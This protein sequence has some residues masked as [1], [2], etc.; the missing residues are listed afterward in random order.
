MIRAIFH[1][2]L[3]FLLP[4][5]VA[6]KFYAE[7]WQRAWLV[8]MAT[9]L[10]DLDH[11]LADPLYAPDRCSIGFHPLHTAWP[12]LIYLLLC[13]W[14]KTRWVGIGLVIHMVLDGIDCWMMFS[15]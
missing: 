15:G 7:R 14:S 8:M 9:M 11:L 10:V 4:A 6:K 5:A 13:F 2:C 3:H 1:L 12:V